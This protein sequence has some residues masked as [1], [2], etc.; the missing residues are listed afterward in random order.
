[1]AVAVVVC[2]A[3]GAAFAQA[4][5]AKFTASATVLVS[6]AIGNP[7]TPTSNTDTLEMLQTE[8]AAVTSDS[9]LEAA[10]D[11][12]S[13][14]GLDASRLRS[15]T[16]VTVPANTQLLRITYASNSPALAP[17]IV[18]SIAQN[19]LDQRT[20]AVEQ[21]KDRTETLIGR[22]IASKREAI[23]DLK[24]D[25][26]ETGTTVK[27]LRSDI[28]ELQTQLAVT[29]AYDDY[30]GRFVSHSNA[31]QGSQQKH[32]ITF[33]L[34]GA[35]LG[36][37]IGVTLA[38]WRERRL[39]RIRSAADLEDYDFDAPIT[40]IDGD[41]DDDAL[42]GIRIRLAPHIRDHAIL[43]L[44][45]MEPAQSLD[46]GVTLGRSL[47]RGGTSVVLI[48]GTGS[49]PGHRDPLGH[50]NDR[51]LAEALT[52]DVAKLTAV[53]VGKNFG[54]VPA[55]QNAAAA[56]EHLVDD[57]ARTVLHYIAERY[58]LT[59]VAAMPFNTAEGEVLARLTEGV[60]LIVQLDRTKHYDL[61]V[62]LKIVGSQKHRL[63]GVFVLPARKK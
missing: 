52:G 15:R 46:A 29:L 17:Q 42:R 36:F 47:S 25:D 38:L 26:T 14:S 53:R 44:V 27:S 6:Q 21:A 3:A 62:A 35:I 12:L 1:V 11:E 4:R 34:A 54:Y 55:G 28:L 18:D 61:G 43:S 30:P 20:V 40:A 33:G 13:I 41:L 58:D 24:G 9:V 50:E 7:F 32:T 37:A 16:V 57:H 8:A 63:L 2:A 56:A 19:Y 59:L 23:H 49:A 45:G 39:D 51:G 22:Q 48:D 31:A 60:L 5:P 10:A